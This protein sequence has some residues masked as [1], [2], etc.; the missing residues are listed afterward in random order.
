MGSPAGPDTPGF[1]YDP[2]SPTP[3]PV[4]DMFT[5][6]N[7]ASTNNNNSVQGG[8]SATVAEDGE[9]YYQAYNGYD[10]SF[11]TLKGWAGDMSY[12]R[13]SPRVLGE[14]SFI[15]PFVNDSGIVDTGVNNYEWP[16]TMYDT[17]YRSTDI[18][19]LQHYPN[20]LDAFTMSSAVG[21]V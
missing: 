10:S 15:P 1:G 3:S 19:H 12:K 14:L 16:Q 6:F 5:S 21:L 4:M 8:Q 13:V 18:Q 11:S 7:P 9:M 2:I 17:S 20:G